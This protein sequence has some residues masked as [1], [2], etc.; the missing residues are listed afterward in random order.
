LR[1]EQG[2][3]HRSFQRIRDKLQQRLLLA[4]PTFSAHLRKALYLVAELQ[5]VP[6]AASSAAHLVSLPEF[7]ELQAAT[8]EQKAKPMLEGIVERLQK[9]RAA[10]AGVRWWVLSWLVRAGVRWCAG[11]RWW[12]AGWAPGQRR[13]ESRAGGC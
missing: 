4:K 8:R 11:G 12:A 13:P 5:A 7:A 3:R 10:A 6:L 9:V 1:R 2:V